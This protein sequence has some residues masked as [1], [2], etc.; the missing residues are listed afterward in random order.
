MA[1]HAV[2]PW[3]AQSTVTL[4]KDVLSKAMSLHTSTA[5]TL[6]SKCA[7]QISLTHPA[8]LSLVVADKFQHYQE[9]TVQ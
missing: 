5:A 3:T 2:K 6:E 1:K 9:A 7:L 4:A 8:K